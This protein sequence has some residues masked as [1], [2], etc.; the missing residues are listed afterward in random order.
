MTHPLYPANASYAPKDWAILAR[1]WHPVALVEEVREDAPFGAVLLDVP[2]VLYRV[3][4]VP[5]VALDRCPHRG[6]RLSLGRV[7]EGKLVCPYHGLEFNHEGRCV[8]VPAHGEQ[9]GPARYLDIPTMRAEERYG[10]VWVCLLEEPLAPLPDW[11][12]IERPDNQRAVMHDHWNASAGRHFENFC[13]LA[14]FSFAHADT[15]GAVDQPEVEPY[16]VEPTD[17]GFRYV[18]DVPMLDSGVFGEGHVR[19]IRCEYHV[20]LPF[21]TRLTMH[22]SKGVEHICDAAS[23]V[24]A[25]RTRIFILKSRDHDQ[26]EPLDEWLRFQHAVNEE[27]RV[28][29]ESQVPIGLPLS[30]GAERHLASDRFS[31]AYRR[32]C[33]DMGLEGPL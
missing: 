12:M 4:G 9:K 21:S 14:H 30:T 19:P 8:R 24:S 31:V 11:S 7:R 20:S 17:G 2:L 25:G 13:D 29:V 1:H 26:E 5:S 16:H 15:F 32:H 18:V 33:T 28:M 22:Y 6:T 3:E 23:P 27:D 10:L